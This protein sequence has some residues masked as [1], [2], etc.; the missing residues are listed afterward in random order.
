M[1]D[2]ETLHSIGALDLLIKPE[3]AQLFAGPVNV[4]AAMRYALDNLLTPEAGMR[5]SRVPR[6]ITVFTDSNSDDDIKA[7]AEE[8]RKRGILVRVGETSK[9]ENNWNIYPHFKYF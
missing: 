1:V 3:Q 2:K 6:A 8:A 7:V 4:G 5:D 9:M